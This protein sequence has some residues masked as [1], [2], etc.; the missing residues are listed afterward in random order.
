MIRARYRREAPELTIA[1]H[2]GYAPAGQDIVCAGVSALTGALLMTLKEREDAGDGGLEFRY[3][4]EE[5]T[6][7]W[8]AERDEEAIRTAFDTVWAGIELLAEEYPDYVRAET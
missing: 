7:R 5:M 2:A 6:V 8:R 4:R 3:D 1:G